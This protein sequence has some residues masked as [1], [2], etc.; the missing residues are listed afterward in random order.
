MLNKDCATT[1]SFGTDID[2][3]NLPILSQAKFDNWTENKK[4]ALA[5]V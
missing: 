1:F 3:N 2:T 5:V 4:H